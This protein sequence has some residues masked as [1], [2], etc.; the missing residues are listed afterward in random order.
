MLAFMR[1]QR[2]SEPEAEEVRVVQ[3]RQPNGYGEK[4]Y[5]D[6]TAQVLELTKQQPERPTINVQPPPH[7][8]RTARSIRLGTHALKDGK[9]QQQL[10]QRSPAR[11]PQ[12][13]TTQILQNVP[14]SFSS[15]PRAP[16][17]APP[18]ERRSTLIVR[19]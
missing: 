9:R 15:F 8:L 19:V 1:V 18:T 7:D 5:V 11:L 16:Y 17:E 10:P 12:P 6:L 4:D 13:W 14:T 2:C 3:Y